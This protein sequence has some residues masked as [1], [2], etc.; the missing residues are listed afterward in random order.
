VGLVAEVTDVTDQDIEFLPSDDLVEDDEPG[1]ADEA[2]VNAEVPDEPRQ[3]MTIEDEDFEADELDE[4]EAEEIE[5]VNETETDLDVEEPVSAIEAIEEPGEAEDDER[6]EDLEEI[7]RRHAGLEEAPEEPEEPEA[8]MEDR[9]PDRVS[10]QVPPVP[11]FVCAGCFLRLP[12]TQLADPARRL[13]A[14][15]ATSS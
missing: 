10:E 7:V 13:C 12:T 8:E 4:T 11:E 2:A 5:G 1:G 9:P 3:R 15:C 6:E 14:D